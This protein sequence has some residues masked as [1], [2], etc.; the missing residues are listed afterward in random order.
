[1]QEKIGVDFVVILLLLGIYFIF[2][3]FAEKNLFD[4]VYGCILVYY[5]IK[6]KIFSTE[7][8]E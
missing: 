1:M 5:H 4:L 7:D 3:Y 2:K 8:I 6:L